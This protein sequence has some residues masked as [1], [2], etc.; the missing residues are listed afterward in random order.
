MSLNEIDLLFS[1]VFLTIFQILSRA[2]ICDQVWINI[3]AYGP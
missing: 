1:S 2:V 3:G